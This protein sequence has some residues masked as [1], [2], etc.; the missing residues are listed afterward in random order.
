M[1]NLFRPIAFKNAQ[2]VKGVICCGVGLLTPLLSAAQDYPSR[3]I[4]MVVPYVT[5]GATD[6][7]GRLMAQRMSE[8]LGQQIVV[9]N[10]GGGASITGTDAVV[11]SAADG[12]TL[13]YGNIALGANPGLF[14]KIP[15]DATRDLAPISEVVTMPTVL[16]VHPSIPVRSVKALITLAKSKPR[17]LNYGSAGNGSVN[18]LTMEVFASVAGIDMVHVP[19][20]GGGPA[21]IDLMGGQLSLM[22]AT[23]VASAQYVKEGRLIGLGMSGAK[24]SPVLPQLPTLNES[25]LPNFDVVEWHLLAAPAHTPSSI[26]EKLNAEIGKALQRPE[27]KDR[28]VALGAD[29][30]GSTVREAGE[31]LNREISRWNKTISQAHIKVAD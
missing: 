18:H 19:Y 11:K 9:D 5:G 20:R 15:Y 24:R 1:N 3:S 21:F 12:Y 28:I 30:V 22:F 4:R 8:S 27:V 26:L 2:L 25:G 14:P 29:A 31:F 13:L 16:V 17:L 10:R 23:V 6:I 7:V